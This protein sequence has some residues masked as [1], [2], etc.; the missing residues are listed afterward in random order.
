[1]VLLHRGGDEEVGEAECPR[2]AE[3]EG[4]LLIPCQ[5]GNSVSRPPTPPKLWHHVL[6]WLQ[7]AW[8]TWPN[9]SDPSFH[10][11]LWRIAAGH[12]R[13]SPNLQVVYPP[14]LKIFYQFKIISYMFLKTVGKEFFP[15]M[16]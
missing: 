1:M 10:S 3:H 8:S 15:I 4:P 13:L 2:G 7:P 9:V 11:P 12:W 6:F 5:C 14:N 16:E